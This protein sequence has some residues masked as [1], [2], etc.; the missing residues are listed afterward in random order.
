MVTAFRSVG[1]LPVLTRAA[2]TGALQTSVITLI[3]NPQQ[4]TPKQ[5][6]LQETRQNC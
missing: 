5:F 1:I 3:C 6:E 4:L 2:G